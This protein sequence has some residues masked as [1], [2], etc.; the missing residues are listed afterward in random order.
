M[1]GLG[2][3]TSTASTRPGPLA[4]GSRFWVSTPSSTKESW[5]RTCGCW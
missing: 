1:A 5:A 4:L 2:T 3:I